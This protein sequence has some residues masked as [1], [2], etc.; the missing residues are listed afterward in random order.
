MRSLFLAVCYFLVTYLPAQDTSLPSL[1]DSLFQLQD[2][3]IQLHYTFDSLV[4]TNNE[5][6]PARISIESASGKFI[7]NTPIA[8]NLRG[9]FRRMKC[10]MP[11]LL[12]NFKKSTLRELH[13]NSIDEIKLVTHCIK[14]KEGQENLQEELMAYQMYS[15]LTPYSYRTIWLNIEYCDVVN[16]DSCISSVGFLIEP[17]K[18]LS[19]RLGVEEKRKFNVSQDSLVYESYR[20]VAAFNFLIGNRDWDVVA[21]RNAKLFFEPNFGKYIVV[22]YDFDYA[23]IVGASYRREIIQA[24][25]HHSYDR[26][27]DGYYFRDQCGETLKYLLT[28]EDTLRNVIAHAPNPMTAERRTKIDGYVEDWFKWLKKMKTGD[29]QYGVVCYYKGGL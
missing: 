3:K 13:L 21:G 15:A 10:D 28:Q 20:L 5:E 23:N 19:E 9:K 22:P 26:I 1:F 6:I 8:L 7:V 24:P 12:L 17:D 29:L 4:K 2:I 25:M 18:V 27:Y 11:P 16:P 14:G